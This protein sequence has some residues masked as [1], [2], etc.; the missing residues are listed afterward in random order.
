MFS[1]L[2]IVLFVIG[3]LLLLLWLYFFIKGQKY[4]DLFDGLSEKDFQLKDIY[5]VGYA[6][7]DAIKY[8]YKSK[9]DR[10]LRK[11]IAIF[12]GE[13][14]VDYYLRVNYAQRVSISLTIA[15]LVVPLYFLANDKMILMVMAMFTWAAYYYYG[16]QISKRIEARS[17]EMLK[18]FSNVVSKLALLTNAGMIMREAWEEVAYTGKSSIYQEM[19]VTVDEMNNGVAEA[20]AFYRFGSRCM[21][22][23]IKKF[24]STIIQGIMKG[25]SDLTVMLQEQSKEVW[26]LK[27]Q[28]V[29]RE[30][31]KANSK[32][33][34]PLMI[35]FIGILI[36]IIIPIFANMGV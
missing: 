17:E 19:Q 2:D 6:L 14:Y 9:S 12:Y 33:L 24:S 29:R 36:M 23:E 15:V 20:D 4:S 31:E 11:E 8:Q 18:D 21:I 25:N 10:I 3:L 13:K 28:L 35:M 22:P 27:K 16:H 30:G 34:I 26:A 5:I 1:P 7:M 32:L